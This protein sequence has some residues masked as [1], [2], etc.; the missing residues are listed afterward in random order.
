MPSRAAEELALE[1]IREDVRVLKRI[2]IEGNGEPSLVSRVTKLEVPVQW[3]IYLSGATLV[4]VIG[5]IVTLFS[6]HIQV[7]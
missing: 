6:S 7:K 5:M 3:A 1:T 2:V 4:A